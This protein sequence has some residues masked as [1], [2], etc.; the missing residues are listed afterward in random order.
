MAAK[1]S[2]YG[3]DQIQVLEG[4]AAPRLRP[5]MYIGDIGKKGYHHLLWEV[6]D[7][8]VDE[9]MGG[10]CDHISV[11]LNPD[12]SA[13]VEDNGRGIPVDTYKTGTQ[14]GKSTVE[15]VLT[16]LHA[17]G[18][19]NKDGYEYS[20]GLHGVGISVV[21]AL[22]EWTRVEVKRDSAVWEI[23]FGQKGSKK[24][25]PPGGVTSPLKKIGKAKASETGTKVTF[26]PDSTI[27]SHTG[28]DYEMIWDRLR[29]TAFLNPV[30]SIS[31]TDARDPDN[32][33][34]DMFDFPN[35][36]A[37][38]MAAITEERIAEY[39]EARDIPVE[40][41][42]PMLPDPIYL[43]GATKGVGEWE[44]CLQW[45]PDHFHRVRSFVNSIETPD[46]GTH[47]I[48]RAHV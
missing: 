10:H 32:I 21:N 7:N 13:T 44:I 4:L 17:G 9:A 33:V 11:I 22:S 20:G 19:F 43:E 1:S 39:S 16:V 2:E 30:V 40:E 29:N 12:G 24:N 31:L 46:G 14:K 42:E 3:A 23:E 41:L 37:D 8:S 25:H 35:G 48:G 5:G 28:W 47:E 36:L 34:E 26:L 27:L 18:K 38:F 6:V 15:V 45:F